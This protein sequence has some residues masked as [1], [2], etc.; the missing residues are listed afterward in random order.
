VG[1]VGWLRVLG[2]SL[3]FIWSAAALAQ[4]P[5]AKPLPANAAELDRLLS[6]R[7]YAKLSQIFRET[8]KFEEVVLNMNWQQTRLFSGGTSFLSFPY[9]ADLDR[10]S[11]A[12]GD[13][14]GVETKKTGILIFLYAYELI[15]IDGQRC[16]DVSAPGHRKDELL[17]SFPNIRKSIPTLSDE[18][19]DKLL[20]TAVQ[21]E[22]LIAPKR[23]DEDF[24]CR[25]GL[26]EMQAAFA[27]YG[28]DAT[29]E[30]PTPP[31]GIGKTM[32][33]KKDPDYKPEFL[34][35]EVWSPKQA[36]LRAKMPDILNNLVS[37]VR[38]K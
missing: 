14:R 32:E 22:S 33:V 30:V 28:N 34:S 27:K 35:K 13:V 24:L 1:L 29:R 4:A 19:K 36:E 7:N 38:K 26:A 10:V 17:T 20:K 5:P 6:Q 23:T 31:G 25:G 8:N 3:W 12:L 9:I 15:L 11:T 21:M 16:K 18:D 37:G 2:G